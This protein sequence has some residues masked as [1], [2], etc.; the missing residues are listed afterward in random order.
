MA[1]VYADATTL[2]CSAL[3]HNP[4]ELPLMPLH[5]DW[6][7]IGF[8]VHLV[9][10]PSQF[11]YLATPPLLEKKLGSDA[12]SACNLDSLEDNHAFYVV[13]WTGIATKGRDRRG[14]DSKVK[15]KD[16]ILRKLDL[17]DKKEFIWAN[18]RMHVTMDLHFSWALYGFGSTNHTNKGEKTLKSVND[19][20]NLVHK[21]L[22]CHRKFRSGGKYVPK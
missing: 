11:Q 22:I 4:Q 5:T 14:S 13:E 10:S 15:K 16:G 7:A 8:G 21:G 20:I 19:L 6:I 2:S 9:S 12:N 18:L 17:K 3:V 1:S